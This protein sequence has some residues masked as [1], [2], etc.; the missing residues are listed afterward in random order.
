[1]TKFLKNFVT[2]T[3][4]GVAVNVFRPPN[5]IDKAIEWLILLDVPGDMVHFL[6]DHNAA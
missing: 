2:L 1:M 3:N 4:A 6:R 5:L